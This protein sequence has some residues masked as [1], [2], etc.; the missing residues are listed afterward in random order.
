MDIRL[1]VD[2]MVNVGNK[3][4]YVFCHD[5]PTFKWGE[6]LVVDRITPEY[7]GNTVTFTD[8]RACQDFEV[9]L[10]PTKVRLRDVPYGHAVLWHGRQ[11]WVWSHDRGGRLCNP[12]KVT[13]FGGNFIDSTYIDADFWV[14]GNA[15]VEVI[16]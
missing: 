8:G 6:C 13:S 2:D 4:R 15:L 16:E 9:E 1:G 3:V 12:Y 5:D 14:G 7:G 10:L 11:F